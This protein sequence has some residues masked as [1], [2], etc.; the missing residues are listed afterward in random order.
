MEVRSSKWLSCRANDADTGIRV[1]NSI[2][3]HGLPITRGAFT[4]G[5]DP[6]KYLSAFRCDLF[7]SADPRDVARALQDGVPAA[8][9]LAPPQ[10]S[11]A[12][13]ADNLVR[14]A[15]DG[16]AVLFD[17]ESELIYQREGLDAFVK[18][19]T[20]NVL[21]P[22]GQGPFVPFLSALRKVRDAFEPGAAPIRTS[23]VT[24]RNAPAHKRAVMTLREWGVHMDEAF[25]LGGVEKADILRALDPDIFFDDQMTPPSQLPNPSLRARR[26][27]HAK[28]G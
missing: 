13:P 25:F 14:I 23:L 10:E 19:E 9:V 22:L 21:V 18:H 28:S 16:D 4:G 12:S 8:R 17:E 20:E 24:S 11:V 7:L 27:T 6:W 5:G 3:A 26:F 2:E 15:F 1:F